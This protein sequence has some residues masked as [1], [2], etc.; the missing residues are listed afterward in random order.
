MTSAD[1]DR[2]WLTLAT[3]V[4]GWGEN[5]GIGVASAIVAEPDRL[6]AL[7]FNGL[8][9]GTAALPERLDPHADRALWCEHSERAALYN[10]LAN[11]ARVTGATLYSTLFPCADCMRGIILSGIAKVKVPAGT[12]VPAA[13]AA[14]I[15]A[16]RRM[17]EEAG[18]SLTEIPMISG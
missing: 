15:A 5:G 17:A 13:F 8:V 7:G 6:I 14:S 2:R 4:A 9:A 18:L 16:S 10:A 3:S 11:S 12:P 1:W